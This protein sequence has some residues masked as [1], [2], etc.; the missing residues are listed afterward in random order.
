VK[1]VNLA[2]WSFVLLLA[3]AADVAIRAFDLGDSVAAPSSAVVAL[4]GGLWS[5]SL[6]SEL[7]TTLKTYAEGL[8]LAIAIGVPAG[9]LIGTSRT[10]RDA[11]SALVELLRPI[12]A[13]ALIPLSILLFGLGTAMHRNVVAF[14]ALWP[15]LVN[16][17]YGVRG[18]D[19]FLHDVARTLGV[20]PAGRLVRV[21]LPAAL[22]SIATGIRISASIALLVC[23]T[24][25]FV[26]GTAGGG[27]IGSYMAVQQNASQIPELYGAIL[28]TALLGYF[29][30]AGLR[31]AERRAIFWGGEERRAGR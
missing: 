19:R 6:S 22:P 17:I 12:P 8:L 21:T 28:A 2:G 29:V 11:T 9:V 1:R 23:V 26:V 30:N 24:A 5:G 10:L 16:T 27:G 15:I 25:E 31:A 14:A 13:V 3:L 20:G 18:T 4:G 7:G